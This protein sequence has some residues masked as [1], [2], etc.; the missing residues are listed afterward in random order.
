MFRYS[1]RLRAGACAV[2][3]GSQVP[4]AVMV[5]LHPP[6]DEAG[7]VSIGLSH[8]M[9]ATLGGVLVWD[10][11]RFRLTVRADG[12]DCRSPWRR[13]FVRWADVV[14]VAFNG[15]VGWF[16]VRAVNGTSVRLPTLVG[17]LDEFLG[18]CER[19][20]APGQ[21]EPARLAY[22]F[23]GRPIPGEGER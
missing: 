5:G 2:A 19:H 14:E 12:L 20:L 7:I 6:K 23:L 15:P 4:V 10:V 16:E 17:G 8:V 21:L 22:V 1:T 9:F 18:M 3:L 11:F 13:R